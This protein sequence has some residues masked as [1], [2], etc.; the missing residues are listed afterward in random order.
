MDI[1]L[2]NSPL[3]RAAWYN[4]K[5]AAARLGETNSQYYPQVTGNVAL[6]RLKVRT[7]GLNGASFGARNHL[8]DL[9]RPFH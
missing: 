6:D 4:A 2:T 8:F 7:V 5:A 3:T 9:H 1:A